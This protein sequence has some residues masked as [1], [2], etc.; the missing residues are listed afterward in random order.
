MARREALG[1]CGDAGCSTA[2]RWAG[3]WE[4]GA[5]G[6]ENENENEKEKE[7]DGGQRSLAFPGFATR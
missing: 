2:L 4:A 3:D 1:Y 5:C 6:A 7:D